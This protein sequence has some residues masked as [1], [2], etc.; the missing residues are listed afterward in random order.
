MTLTIRLCVFAALA[1]AAVAAWQWSASLDPSRDATHLALQ[2]FDN[3]STLPD[4]LQEAS[5]LQNWWPFVW[6]LMLALVGVVMFW[7]DVE[8]WWKHEQ[9]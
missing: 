7:D 6:P 5:L 1:L 8:R 4:K 2:Q 3:D 9:S